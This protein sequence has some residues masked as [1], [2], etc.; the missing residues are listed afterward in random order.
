MTAVYRTRRIDGRTT[1]ERVSWWPALGQT[2]TLI[3]VTVFPFPFWA[4]A[5]LFGGLVVYDVATL[6]RRELYTIVTTAGVI[7]ALFVVLAVGTSAT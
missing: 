5:V 7:V 2:A 6:R 4:L 3:A 1:V